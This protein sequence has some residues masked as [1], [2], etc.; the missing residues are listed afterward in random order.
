MRA[1]LFELLATTEPV[2]VL[3]GDSGTGKSLILLEHRNEQLRR[4]R[5][6]PSVQTCAFDDGALQVAVMDSLAEAITTTT[7]ASG[8]SSLRRRLENASR[9]VAA[10]V[11]KS[12]AKAVTHEL[13][14]LVKG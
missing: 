9:E 4:G 14:A 6:A 3:C 10:E 2:V 7:D 1:E 8:W 12:L 13:L 5:L 11:G